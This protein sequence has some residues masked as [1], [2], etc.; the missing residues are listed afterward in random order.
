MVTT[1]AETPI[2]F[3]AQNFHW[4]EEGEFT[5]ELSTRLL[6]EAGARLFMVGH[7]ER[8]TLF[9]ETDEIIN[10][11][12][13]RTLKQG[14][15]TI[16]CVG[17]RTWG[18]SADQL[19]AELDSQLCAA[20]SGVR[21]RAATELVVAYEPYWAIGRA[22]QNPASA[23]RLFVA[24]TFIRKSLITIFGNE[25]AIPIIYGGN[26]NLENCARLMA[27]GGVDGLF[28][29]QAAASP[30]SFASV[31]ERALSAQLQPGNADHN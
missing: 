29:G 28:V 11:K 10:R 12:V 20:L 5:G 7:A 24:A 30:T 8:R 13:Q 19:E 21:P 4:E 26:V 1:G 22:A 2:L 9:G 18:V 14:L 16:L 27:E 31:I 3:G 6:W 15:R 23:E 25:H 17:E